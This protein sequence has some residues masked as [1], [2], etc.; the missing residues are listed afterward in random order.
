MFIATLY[1]AFSIIFG[2]PRGWYSIFF[3]FFF[4]AMQC[5]LQDLNSQAGIEPQA[6]SVKALSLNLWTIREFSQIV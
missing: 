4:L 5:S 3:F 2:Q 6:T 1:Y